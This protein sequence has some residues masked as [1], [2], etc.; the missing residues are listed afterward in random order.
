VDC[1]VTLPHTILAWGSLECSY[2]TALPDGTN[3]VNTATVTTTG[4]VGGGEGTAD[5][6]FGDPTEV[7]D[8]EINVTDTNGESWGPVSE[9]TEWTYTESFECSSETGIYGDNG[10]YSYPHDNTATIVETEQEDS[11]H[12][13]VYCY[14]PVV[15]KDA[16]TSYTRTWNWEITKTVDPEAHALFA[17]ESADSTYT[18]EVEK[19][20]STDTNWAVEGTIAVANPH[21]DESMTVDVSDMVS[22]GIGATVDCGEGSPELTVAA[23]SSGTCS[24]ST[25][26]PD[27]ADRTNTATATLNDIDFTGTAAVTFGDPTEVVDDEINVTD[28]NDMSWGPVSIG[29]TW[30]YDKTFSCSSDPL[31]YGS[32]GTYSYGHD[33][34][35]TIVETKQ[36]DSAHVDVDCYAPIVTKTVDESFTR[37]WDWEVMKEVVGDTDITLNDGQSYEA[38]WKVVATAMGYDDSE[39]AVS[40]T[41]KVVNPHPTDD[42]T[43]ALVDE[44]SDGTVAALDCAGSLLVP[45]DG[46]ATCDYSA[47]DPDGD[48][49]SN[50]VT[51]T[52]NDIAFEYTE[53][54]VYDEPTTKVNWTILVEDIFNNGAP[55]DLF[56]ATVDESPKTF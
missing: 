41:I 52:F 19:I 30:T 35:A 12:V 33:N 26:L 56:T 53:P 22:G 23:D 13:D 8:D 48:A 43:V 32:N 31:D 27:G 47:E 29:T 21:P 2:D 17:G 34:T 42:M 16:D 4:F 39:W 1:G 7:V 37:T 3:R 11:A 18:V 54:V 25:T 50:T 45:A 49:T 28:T 24:Y 9:Y 6:T 5:V 46:M 20:D 44:L 38:E 10:M 14:A 36:D 55:Y 40:G 51:A 15:T